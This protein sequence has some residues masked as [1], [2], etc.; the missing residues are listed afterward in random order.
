MGAG[1]G[2]NALSDSFAAE[3]CISPTAPLSYSRSVHEVAL[4]GYEDIN[5]HTDIKKLVHG[6][7]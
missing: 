4:M 5:I 6:D 3:T 7:I 1:Q 2:E